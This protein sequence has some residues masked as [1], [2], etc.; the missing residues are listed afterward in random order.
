MS[1]RT[2]STRPPTPGLSIRPGPSLPVDLFALPGLTGA[3]SWDGLLPCWWADAALRHWWPQEVANMVVGYPLMKPSVRRRHRELTRIIAAAGP[4]RRSHE[5]EG[6]ESER[7]RVEREQCGPLVLTW[8][9]PLTPFSAGMPLEE[10]QAIVADLDEDRAVRVLADGALAHY[11]KCAGKHA[12]RPGL[13]LKR[14]LQGTFEVEIAYRRPPGCPISRT[15]SPRINRHHTSGPPPH[16]LNAIEALCVL[17][18]ADGAWVWG[19][20]GIRHYANYT[21]IWLAKHQAWIEARERGVGL[22]H[23]WPGS[24]VG[25]DPA[26]L[27]RLLRPRD[28]CR[29]GSGKA[30][31]DCCSRT[32]A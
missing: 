26:Q 13:R 9:G 31:G 2:R 18:P 19:L 30:Y 5:L 25:H 6:P 7:E 23:A 4:G 20:H 32:D 16:L 21:A 17:F 24:V 1:G 29:C 10:V 8:R 12:P 28:P 3:G 22:D 27:Q 14:V 11:E 15:I